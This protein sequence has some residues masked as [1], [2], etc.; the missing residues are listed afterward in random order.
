M[1]KSSS[2]GWPSDATRM[3]R[4]LEIA[5]DDEVLMREVHRLADL[6]NEVEPIG[7]RQLRRVAM[8]VD[9]LPLDIFHDEVGQPVRRG[10]AVE[11][12]CDVGVVDAGKDLALAPETA[13]DLVVLGAGSEQLDRDLL[14]VLVVVADGQEDRAHATASE[15]LQNAVGSDELRCRRPVGRRNSAGLAGRI[16]GRPEQVVSGEQ[17]FD[18][19]PEFMVV[20]ADPA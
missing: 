9:R 17:P 14:P 3:F 6:A 19:V 18:L 11:Q 1:P 5:M 7:D 16:Q 4:R 8:P 13:N 2:F 20:A 15:L 10:S 12:L